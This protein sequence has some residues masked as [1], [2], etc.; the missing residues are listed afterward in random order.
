[1]E[2]SAT[3]S[4]REE[5]RVGPMLGTGSKGMYTG[6][7]IVQIDSVS[8]LALEVIEDFGQVAVGLDIAR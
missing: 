3:T 4:T 1:M 8:T 2:T 7:C 6:D 5:V